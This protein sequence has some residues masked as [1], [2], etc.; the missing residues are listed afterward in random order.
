MGL[1]LLGN[2]R[3]WGFTWDVSIE[4]CRKVLCCSSGVL[5]V[6]VV[7]MA[8]TTCLPRRCEWN[9]CVVT[10]TSATWSD[11]AEYA[12]VEDD[13]FNPIAPQHPDTAVFDTDWSRRYIDVIPST[14]LQ[15]F[16][17]YVGNQLSVDRHCHYPNPNPALD[18]SYLIIID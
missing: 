10:T 15:C 5:I 2:G 1:C 12:P 9:S 6:L 14:Q 11:I 8:W 3:E 16:L 18:R 4:L 17:Q 13:T 7:R